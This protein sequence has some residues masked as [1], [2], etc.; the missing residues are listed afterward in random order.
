MVWFRFYYAEKSGKKMI[1]SSSIDND[2][3]LDSTNI[4]RNI[5]VAQPT[6]SKQQESCIEGR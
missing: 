1:E 2:K 6:D 5:K 4:L 3:G